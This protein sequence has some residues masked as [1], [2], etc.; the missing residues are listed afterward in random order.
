MTAR[1]A[2]LA[3]CGLLALAAAGARADEPLLRDGDEAPTFSGALLNAE[4]A[5]A[6]S[7]ELADVTGEEPSDASAKA[8]IVTFFASWCA[9]CQRELPLLQA[10]YAELRPKGLRVVSISIDSAEAEL[11]KLIASQQITFPVVKDRFHIVARRWLGART[12]LPSL[13]IVGRDGAVK[14]VK[15]GYST[16]A[17]EFL[18]AEAERALGLGSAPEAPKSG[19]GLTAKGFPDR[20]YELLVPNDKKGPLPLVVA[21]HCFGCEV[22]DFEQRFHIRSLPD[23]AGVLVAVPRGLVDK[24]G[25]P[26]WNAEGCCD[27]E[28]RAPDDAGYVRAV[29]EDV[30]QRQP[31]DASRVYAFGFSNGGFLAHKLACEFPETFA[32]IA[33]A[34]GPGPQKCAADKPVAVLQIHGDRDELVPFEGEPKALSGNA[35][36]PPAEVALRGWAKR[37]GC[38]AKPVAAGRLDLVTDVEGE[39]TEVLE[40]RGCKAAGVAL[41]KMHGVPHSPQVQSDFTARAVRWLLAHPR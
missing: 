15:H 37:D 21:L 18:R 7:F 1:G 36:L 31:V 16:D 9:P 28:G 29:V 3:A 13:F 6:P 17:S 22:G 10:L 27:M 33:S 24:K 41:W 12:V 11:A 26:F 20:P 30:K 19:P 23:D 14:L 32:G 39:E 25:R 5:G 34:A 2:A 40:W 4:A 8:T 35:P 38:A